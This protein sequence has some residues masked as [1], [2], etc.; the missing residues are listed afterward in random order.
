[1]SHEGG[2]GGGGGGTKAGEIQKKTGELIMDMHPV[3]GWLMSILMGG[4]GGKK[5]GH[6]GGHH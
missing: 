6:G 3:F 4:G 2:H 1:M 5:G